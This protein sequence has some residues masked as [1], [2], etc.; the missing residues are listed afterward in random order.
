MVFLGIEHDARA[1]VIRMPQA[2][3]RQMQQLLHSWLHKTDA[4]VHELMVLTGCLCSALQVI[5]QGRMFLRRCYAAL[6]FGHGKMGGRPTHHLIQQ[7]KR[8]RISMSLDL[9]RDIRWWA[10]LMQH[11]NGSV[12]MRANP[13]RHPDHLVWTDASNFAMAGVYDGQ[14]WQRLYD[15]QLAFMKNPRISIAAKEMM[16]VA[17]SCAIWGDEWKNSH[18]RFH[19][20]NKGDV[21]SFRKQ[22]NK[23][24]LTQHLMR[25]I[26]LQAARFGFS[27]ELVWIST[28]DNIVADAVSRMPLCDIHTVKACN[29]LKRLRTSD[30]VPPSQDDPQWEEAYLEGILLG[31]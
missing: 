6:S 11:F 12:R 16:A 4:T 22:A 9:Q 29:S 3:L 17:I 24:P 20:D 7:W 28:H 8:R 13:T 14:Y 25:V 26:A 1:L 5:P 21:D 23:N 19:C 15:G 10:K 18:V 31:H 2:R 27:F 30:W